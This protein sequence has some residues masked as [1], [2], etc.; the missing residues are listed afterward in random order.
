[1]AIL[2]FDVEITAIQV[3]IS[4]GWVGGGVTD[5]SFKMYKIKCKFQPPLE[6]MIQIPPDH[7]WYAQIDKYAKDIGLI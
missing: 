1:M 4:K 2:P 7:K 3:E 6:H 5:P